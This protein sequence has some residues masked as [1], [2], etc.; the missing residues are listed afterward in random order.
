MRLSSCSKQILKSLKKSNSKSGKNSTCLSVKRVKISKIQPQKRNRNRC[1]VFINGEYRFGVTKEL[2]LKYDLKEDDQITE[3]EIQNLLLRDEKEKI[4]NR[5]YRLL[6][7]RERSSREM[8]ER[9]MHAGFDAHLVDDVVHGLIADDTLNDER[10]AQAF[11][12][13]YT[14]VKPKGNRF[15][16]RE[17]AKKGIAKETIENVLKTR[18]EQELLRQ[19]IQKK[20]K[21]LDPKDFKDRQKLIR[22]LLHHGFTP[23]LVYAA[24][25]KRS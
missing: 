24:L 8:R 12:Q 16:F 2:L 9:L 23:E 14:R 7:Y 15:I 13:D 22:R 5:A 1:S 4:R 19:F 18:D 10:F 20:L 17:L 25:N 3:D 11:V 21:Q 6:S